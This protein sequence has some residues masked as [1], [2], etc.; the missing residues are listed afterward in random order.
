MPCDHCNIL[1]FMIKISAEEYIM[2]NFAVQGKF[3]GWTIE[4]DGKK[5]DF[6]DPHK[7][8]EFMRDNIGPAKKLFSRFTNGE[9]VEVQPGYNLRDVPNSLAHKHGQLWV[10]GPSVAA[11]PKQVSV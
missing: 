3:L 9:I 10:M 6:D 11:A 8:R 2:S 7:F 5:Y 4:V 1:D